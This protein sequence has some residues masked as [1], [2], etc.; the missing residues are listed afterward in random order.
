LCQITYY[1]RNSAL[2][3]TNLEFLES[4]CGI[5]NPANYQVKADD[6]NNQ[7]MKTV[8]FAGFNGTLSSGEQIMSLSPPSGDTLQ[9]LFDATA[10]VQDI[11][12]VTAQTTKQ[13][14]DEGVLV[15]P[16]IRNLLTEDVI[17][18]TG[19]GNEAGVLTYVAFE[20]AR[21]FTTKTF[22]LY[23]IGC[24]KQGDSNYETLI[25]NLSNLEINLINNENDTMI[26]A[27]PSDIAIYSDFR[28]IGSVLKS[29][30]FGNSVDLLNFNAILNFLTKNQKFADIVNNNS[31]LNYRD[32]F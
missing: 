32:Q 3:N 28:Q 19:H 23:L 27:P 15:L 5:V 18:L 21:E 17:I 20:L 14:Y 4:N 7:N 13:F 8:I 31:I 25:N 9:Y 10:G 16:V 30:T 22:K 26:Q 6:T 24:P 11:P 2:F 29:V 12:G 1:A